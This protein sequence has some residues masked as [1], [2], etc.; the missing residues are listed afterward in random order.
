MLSSN[1]YLATIQ[2]DLLLGLRN[3]GRLLNPLLFYGL[4]ALLFPLALGPEHRLLA[5]AAPGIIWVAALLATL[6]TLDSL[7]RGDFNDGSLEL[8][9]LS[10]HPFVLLVAAKLFAQ[11]L[12]T[13]LPLILLTPV[14]GMF[15]SLTGQSIGILL[16]T[17]L[18]GTPTI[19][20]IG[21]IGA[22]LTLN[23]RGAGG[24]ALLALLVLPLYIPVLIF[25]AG[26]IKAAG[27]GL[28]VDGQLFFMAALLVLA[29]TLAPAAVA[30]ALKINMH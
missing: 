12:L 9:A 1:P 4:V 10:P 27:A 20:L 23:I 18:L 2:R 13:G 6:M 3:P 8:L 19:S 17:L 28:P 16:L 7:F 29:I 5:Q 14:L 11:W 15:F 25:A 26:T 24:G 30:A 22:A 21:A